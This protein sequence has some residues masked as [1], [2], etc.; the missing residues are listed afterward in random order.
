MYEEIDIDK[1]RNDMRDECFG[2]YFDG[3]FGAALIESFDVDKA[4]PEKIV[5]MAQNKGID[6]RL[7]QLKNN[8]D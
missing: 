8:S 3:G 1:I 5:E 6:L 2:A 7:Y 4:T